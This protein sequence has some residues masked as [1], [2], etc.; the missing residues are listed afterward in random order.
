MREGGR[1]RERKKERQRARTREGERER[2]R[3]ISCTRAR[4]RTCTR[5]RTRARTR[6]HT[7]SLTFS[8]YLVFCIFFFVVVYSNYS[9]F[10][11]YYCSRGAHLFKTEE[12]LAASVERR[13]LPPARADFGSSPK[14]PP[15]ISSSA[16]DGLLPPRELGVMPPLDL[17]VCKTP[18]K[19]STPRN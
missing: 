14:K 4:T 2:E 3:L 15:T 1:E 13:L 5:T 8:L 12:G 11:G 6:T 10:C 18:K 16:P 9:I 7:L 17:G 19:K